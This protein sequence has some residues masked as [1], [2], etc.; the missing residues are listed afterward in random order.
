[1]KDWPLESKIQSLHEVHPWYRHRRLAWSMGVCF[2][3][4]RRLMKKF[5][6]QAKVRIRKKFT[7]TGDI[8]LPDTRIPNLT[9][10]ICPIRANVI[11]RTDFTHIIYHGIHLYLATVIDAYTR[12]I[13]GYSISFVHT[14][15]FALE[16]I[17]M[18]LKDTGSIPQIFHSDQWS[19]YRSFLIMNHLSSLGIQISMS[20]K[21]APWE[22]GWQ[23]SYYGKFKLELD[24]PNTYDCIED[25]IANIHYRIYYYNNERIHTA[26]KMPPKKFVALLK[27]R[28][29]VKKV[30]IR[31]EHSNSHPHRN[32]CSFSLS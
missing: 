16:A 27:E 29:V 4:A 21:W 24:A 11:W 18:A 31:N 14:K 7:K 32:P 1:M 13:I 20:K 3:K 19:E 6:I 22:N 2:E 5:S 30:V 25:L 17:Q 23:E 12:E 9:K 8:W 15:E 10:S 26:I 28:G